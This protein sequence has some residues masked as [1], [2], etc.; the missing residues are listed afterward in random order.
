MV[1]IWSYLAITWGIWLP[2]YL[3]YCLRGRCRSHDHGRLAMV[4]VE[5][6][7]EERPRVANVMQS[8]CVWCST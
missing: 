4:E 5:V 3:V 7:V 6:E 8:V 2:V 1:N